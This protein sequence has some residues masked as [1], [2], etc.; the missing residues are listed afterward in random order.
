M[1][2]AAIRQLA[3]PERVPTLLSSLPPLGDKRTAFPEG[4]PTVVYRG[5][6]DGRANYFVRSSSDPDAGVWV[7]V[8]ENPI[9]AVYSYQLV[10]DLFQ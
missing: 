7:T 9:R 5:S 8:Q 6:K 10:P 4:A 3:V 1:D 2:T